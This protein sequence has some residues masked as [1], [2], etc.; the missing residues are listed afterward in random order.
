MFHTL[1][2]RCQRQ[3]M[4]PLSFFTPRVP[5]ISGNKSVLLNLLMDFWGA[6]LGE[7]SMLK[8]LFGAVRVKWGKGFMRCLGQTQLGLIG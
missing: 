3:M 8:I 7:V 6:E 1:R 5:S 2:C 4:A